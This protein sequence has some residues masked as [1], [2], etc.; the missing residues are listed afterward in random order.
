VL[1]AEAFYESVKNC[2]PHFKFVVTLPCELGYSTLQ[3]H[4]TSV[5]A[6]CLCDFYVRYFFV[7]KVFSDKESI[8]DS[9]TVLQR[10]LYC[11]RSTTV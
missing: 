9:L 10:I 5:V 4:F 11:I 1:S 3:Q 6:I 8:S 2:L 7:Y